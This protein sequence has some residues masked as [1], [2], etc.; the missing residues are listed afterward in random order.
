MHNKNILELCLAH[1]LG[2]LELFTATCY[3]D[4]SKKNNL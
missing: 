1:G 2:G 3:K 4:F